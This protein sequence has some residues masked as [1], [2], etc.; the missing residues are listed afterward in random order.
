MRIAPK[1]GFKAIRNERHPE[2]N[3]R[4]WL[5]GDEDFQISALFTDQLI[6]PV[7]IVRPSRGVLDREGWR[8][9]YRLSPRCADESR[10][11][12]RLL[13]FCKNNSQNCS[14]HGKVPASDS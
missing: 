5:R 3:K 13:E 1:L 8:L 4:Y 2:F 12:R 10:D 9:A 6:E 14:C 11:N 7:G